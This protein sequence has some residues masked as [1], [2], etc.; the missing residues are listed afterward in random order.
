MPSLLNIVGTILDS[1]PARRRTQLVL[2]M[3]L[4]LVGAMAEMVSLGAIVPFLA[5]LADPVHALNQ[6]WVA[7]VIAALGLDEAGDLRWQLTLV[8]AGTV[9]AAGTLRFVLIFAIAK[10]NYG[11]GHELGAEVF[12]RTLYQ[13][14]DVQVTRNSSSILASINKVD[15][16]VWLA[17]SLLNTV[18]AVT[19]A[20]CIVVTL[21]LVDPLP[22]TIALFSFG[23]IYVIVSVVTRKRFVAAS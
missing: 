6:A 11:I 5:I 9:V 21:V 15:E 7:K 8:F 13:P 23:T 18:S 10:L 2:L 1:L 16:V 22:A 20:C 4:M 12:R 3:G 17:F 14:Y 19:M